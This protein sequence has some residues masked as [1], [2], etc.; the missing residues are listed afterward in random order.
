MKTRTN[1]QEARDTRVAAS[2]SLVVGVFLLLMKFWA[3]RMTHSQA[4][5]SDAMESIVNVVAAMV[6]IVVVVVAA[7]PADKEHPYGHGKI[8]FFSAAFEGGLIAFAAAMIC[9]EA[10]QALIS[11]RVVH[12]VNFGITVVLGAGIANLLLGVFLLRAGKR[13]RSVALVASGH[14]VISDFWTSAGVAIGLVLVSVTG[15]QWLD[16]LIALVVGLLLARTGW[17]LVRRSAGGLLDEED[18]ELLG[19]LV[20]IISQERGEGIIQ[21][22]HCRVIRA[23]QYHHIDAHVVVPEFWDVAKAHHETEDFERRVIAAYEHDGE[24]HFHVDPCRR[25]Y[26]RGC[27]VKECP[28]RRHP[29]E[30]RRSLTIDELTNPDEPV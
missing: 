4:V 10:T 22:H 13:N 1:I 28:I 2:L 14:H 24:L 25:A 21:V 17:V 20:Q 19:S 27:D 18:R 8:E 26:C 3:Y 9:V 23:G 11:G 16:P 12:E 6:S 7:R 15:L 30:A 5:F 29:F